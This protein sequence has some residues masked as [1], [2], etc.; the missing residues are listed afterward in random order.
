[1][2]NMFFAYTEAS[3]TSLLDINLKA[4]IPFVQNKIV[5]RNCYNTG[6]VYWCCYIYNWVCKAKGGFKLLL[7]NIL[8]FYRQK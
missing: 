4:C 5:Q 1:M 6:G 2:Q 7:F 3:G 8:E